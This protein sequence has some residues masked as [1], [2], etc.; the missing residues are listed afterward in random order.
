[1]W[2][3]LKMWLQR[4]WYNYTYIIPFQTSIPLND[5]NHIG[6]LDHAQTMSNKNNSLVTIMSNASFTILSKSASNALLASSSSENSRVLQNWSCYGNCL[7]LSTRQ[8][9]FVLHQPC[10]QSAAKFKIPKYVN[11]LY[12]YQ[13]E[14]FI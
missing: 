4:V 3:W 2:N 9:H 14:S 8:L 1:M 13:D 10:V 11:N 12:D 6:I 7:L 5:S